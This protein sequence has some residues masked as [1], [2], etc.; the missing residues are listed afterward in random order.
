[1]SIIKNITG[2]SHTPDILAKTIKYCH[3]PYKTGNGKIITYMGCSQDDPIGSMMTVK[4]INYKENGRQFE[5]SMLSITPAPN[6]YSN[7][8]LLG[9]A[10]ECAEFWYKKGFQC[11]VALHLDSDFRHF[12]IVINSVSFKNGKKIKISPK[13][14]N[15]YKTHCSRILS[16]YGLD[17]IRT[18]VAKIIDKDPHS[19]EDELDFLEGYDE[20][21]ADNGKCLLEMMIESQYLV[22]TTN[23]STP[24][25]KNYNP[26][27]PTDNGPNRFMMANDS[28]YR[29]FYEWA[30]SH[31]NYKP[32]W[33][34]E[35][36]FEPWNL[37]PISPPSILDITPK[38]IIVRE[39]GPDTLVQDEYYF[40]DSGALLRINCSRKYEITVPD[41]Y[42][43]GQI[44]HIVEHLPRM[45]EEEKNKHT[46]RATA[47]SGT[48][49][50]R[51][52]DGQV[53]LDFSETIKL[54]WSD[55][56][57]TTLPLSELQIY[58]SDEDEDIIDVEINDD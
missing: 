50:N 4:R 27:A 41:N 51:D 56:S 2:S 13:D 12:H 22:T 31:S 40:S 43:E 54:N 19:F 49:K 14:Y 18:P 20:I 38:P 28:A 55:G 8:E 11:T 24:T 25:K 7:E 37:K 47:A 17:P 6:Q 45:S 33:M 30:N 10:N 48:F 21:M 57:S 58:K 52:I 36:H 34:S 16:N 9:I 44:K 15:D 42:T 32:N 3:E 23:D 53:E 35:P 46:K 29:A 26:D 39:S 5:E 1:M